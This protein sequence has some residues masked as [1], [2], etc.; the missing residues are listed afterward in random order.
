MLRITKVFLSMAGYLLAG[1]G[2]VGDI[3]AGF[4][5][6]NYR[7]ELGLIIHGIATL[8]W[9][10]GYMIV[11]S[12]YIKLAA[13]L[14]LFLF[15]GVGTFGWTLASGIA[16]LSAKR[17]KE[18]EDEEEILTDLSSDIRS[19]IETPLETLIQPIVEVIQI[20]DSKIKRAALDLI[21]R[22]PSP[23][24]AVFA[25]R[26]LADPDPD[27]RALAAV[28]IS[29]LELRMSELIK[30]TLSRVETEP[31]DPESH[32]AIGRVY[33]D[34][35]GQSGA[36]SMNRRFY[37]IQAQQAFEKAINLDPTRGHDQI[38]LAETLLDLRD[39]AKAWD[40]F[41]KISG[42]RLHGSKIYLLGLEIALRERRFDRVVALAKQACEAL[43]ESDD[44]L[45]VMR[46]WLA[47]D[48][49]ENIR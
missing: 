26:F 37:L 7:L 21:C 35:A 8:I 42:E 6:L 39:Y 43:S 48:A 28:A 34:C 49:T 15:P 9:V 25:R 46:W 29:R 32:A 22:E 11:D 12:A 45:P 13:A 17:K 24:A 36:D 31:Q 40:A 14:G 5:I 3:I 10:M 20:S 27:V 2:L 18:T 47:V 30:S 1:I 4:I 33:L 44:L 38:A 23:Q 41:A 19:A 16:H